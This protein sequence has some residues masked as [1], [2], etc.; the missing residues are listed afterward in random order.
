MTTGVWQSETAFNP[1]NIED[2]TDGGSTILHYHASDRSRANHTG[3]Q[4]SSTI[5]DLSTTISN[6]QDTVLV[7][8]ISATETANGIKTSFTV[9]ENVTFGNILYLKSDGKLW[10]ADANG[11][12]TYPALY[13]AT[14]AKSA[15]EVCIVLKNGFIR[16]NS[17]SFTVGSIIYLSGTAG[18]ITSTIPAISGDAIQIIGIAVSSNTIDFNPQL[19][20]ITIG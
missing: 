3:T 7:N 10:K 15:D 20:Y 5:S 17:W 6:T 4:L 18:S 8:A 14:E 9:G 1:T 11:T 2:L 19:S 13:I 12:N 16:L